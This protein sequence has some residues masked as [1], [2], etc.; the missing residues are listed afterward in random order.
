[1]NIALAILA[2]LA[3]SMALI[4]A[5]LA[6]IQGVMRWA[7]ARDH[8]WWAFPLYMAVCVP[9]A[10]ACLAAL[11]IGNLVLVMGITQ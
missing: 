11:I 9:S 1:M 6:F 4:F 10:L 7:A 3:F 2:S 8:K 5:A